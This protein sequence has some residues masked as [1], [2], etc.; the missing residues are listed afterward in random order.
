M[1]GVEGE[2]SVQS[3]FFAARF[4]GSTDRLG[5]NAERAPLVE[6]V[7]GEEVDTG[8]VAPDDVRLSDTD[9]TDD[10]VGFCAMSVPSGSRSVS[11]T[12]PESTSSERREE[13]A[14]PGFAT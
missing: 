4:A 7:E 13:R 3:A 1:R 8:V 11:T 10:C 9:D 14:L 2:L 12:K 5:S 6:G